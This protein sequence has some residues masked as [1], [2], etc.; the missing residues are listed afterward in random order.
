MISRSAGKYASL[1]N[2]TTNRGPVEEVRKVQHKAASHTECQN[3]REDDGEP[4]PNSAEQYYH[5]LI[6]GDALEEGIDY[7]PETHN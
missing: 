3:N 6:E 5:F 7:H 4:E 1:I 2:L